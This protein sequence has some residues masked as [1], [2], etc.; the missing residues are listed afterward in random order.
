M[1]QKS[2]LF[3]IHSWIVTSKSILG[4][5]RLSVRGEN[6]LFWESKAFSVQNKALFIL[7]LWHTEV[8]VVQNIE[9]RHIR[10]RHIPSRPQRPL[11]VSTAASHLYNN[12]WWKLVCSVWSQY[13]L[14]F[15]LPLIIPLTFVFQENSAGS[16]I[17]V[18]SRVFH[19]TVSMSRDFVLSVV[20]A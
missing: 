19:G 1:R 7:S 17:S 15:R 14:T 6:V 18:V 4:C 8:L 12:V 10:W 11:K 9:W 2:S 20:C 3:P 13:F 5:G 16:P